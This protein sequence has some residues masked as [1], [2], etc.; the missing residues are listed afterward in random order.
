M[1]RSTVSRSAACGS[2]G[3]ARARVRHPRQELQLP[4]IASVVHLVVKLR[5]ALGFGSAGVSDPEAGNLLRRTAVLL[6]GWRKRPGP[7]AVR[8]RRRWG[9]ELPARA[10]FKRFRHPPPDPLD[11][12]A[13]VIQTL[14]C[15]TR[16]EPAPAATSRGCEIL[17]EKTLQSVAG[18]EKPC[19][20]AAARLRLPIERNLRWP[21]SCYDY[22]PRWIELKTT[23]NVWW[24]AHDLPP[25]QHRGRGRSI[26]STPRGWEASGTSRLRGPA[27]GLQ[28]VQ[29][30]FPRRPD[31]GRALPAQAAASSPAN[32]TMPTDRARQ[33]N[34]MF[35]T[36]MGRWR[37]GGH[38]LLAAPRR[39]RDLRQL[40]QCREL[41]APEATLRDRSDRQGIPQ[42]DHAGQLLFRTREFEQMRC[43]SSSARV[44]RDCSISGARSVSPGTSDRTA[45]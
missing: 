15:P 7:P 38:R 5:S 14:R 28:D 8:I 31:R 32:T 40:P 33:F 20:C 37:T 11:P 42:R 6:V 1:P 19:R 21:N 35:K 24:R 45:A 4:R 41:V 44:R 39:R 29:V 26:L 3:P 30:A 23:S 18:M 17:E 34:L 10:I 27:R 12:R 13:A 36:F 25:R 9:G 16:R 2:R 43:S 22:G